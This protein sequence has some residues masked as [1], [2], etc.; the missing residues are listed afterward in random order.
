MGWASRE[1]TRKDLDAR[2]A[3][4]DVAEGSLGSLSGEPAH[5]V[6][7][8]RFKDPADPR[9]QGAPGGVR[10]LYKATFTFA[11]P[12]RP[13][14]P[15]YEHSFEGGLTGDSHLA[16]TQPAYSPPGSADA[17]EILAEGN[18]DG[19]TYR[20]SG[21]PNDRGF[22][23]KVVFEPF[24]AAN[25][26]DAEQRAHRALAPTLSN[27]AAHLDIPLQVAQVDVVELRTGNTQMS[28]RNPF[29]EVPFQVSGESSLHPEFRSAVSLY[30]E[31]LESSS[32][33]Y[34][35]LCLFKIIEGT[36]SLRRRR[37]REAARS[38]QPFYRPPE[39]IPVNDADREPWLNGIF[40]VRPPRWDQLT[41]DSIFSPQVRGKEFE[42]LVGEG[43][44]RSRAAVLRELRNDVA[45]ALWDRGGG[46][47]LTLSADELLHHERV[48][49]WLP[50]TRCIA[51]Y[52]LKHEFPDEFL[53]YLRD[54]GTPVPKAPS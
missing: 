7:V 43:A 35:F 32:L 33:V 23:G 29:N 12:G 4:P 18:V 46:P 25:L 19:Q 45:H 30:R 24:D 10:G 22:L 31:A 39:L 20:W 16:I 6:V 34:R 11:R 21:L 1:R 9:N 2:Q 15:E 53:S 3:S 37:E 40:A 5:I 27:W 41:L 44:G 52:M 49:A 54:D 14:T 8:N 17:T 50:L 47:V 26:Q 38:G 13:L 48:H 51:R 42:E 28:V 36:R